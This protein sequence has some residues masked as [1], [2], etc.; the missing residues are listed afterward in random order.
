MFKNILSSMEGVA[1]YPIISLG[2]FVLFFIT[3]GYFVF[4]A[5]KSFIEKMKNMP[6][7]GDD[8]NQ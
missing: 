7:K 1:I 6:L 5:D 2:I 4:N 3:L 8:S